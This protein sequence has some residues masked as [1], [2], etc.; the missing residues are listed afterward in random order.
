MDLRDMSR[1][2]TNFHEFLS[3][4]NFSNFHLQNKKKKKLGTRAEL[5]L[6]VR[7]SQKNKRY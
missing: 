2:S 5:E 6:D 7:N 4:N 3:E 1:K